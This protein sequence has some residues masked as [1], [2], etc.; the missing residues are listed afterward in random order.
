MMR[1]D[2]VLCQSGAGTRSQVKKALKAGQVMVNGKVE[3][4]PD[5]KV[6]P[7]KDQICLF[8]KKVQ[9]SRYEYYMLYKPAGYVSACRDEKEKTVLELLGEQRR[10]DLFPAGRLDKDTEGLLLITNDGKL[11]HNLLSPKKH[12]DKT[13]YAELLRSLLPDDKKRLE[14]GVDIGDEKPALPAKITFPGRD[15]SKVEITIKEGRFHQIK[16]MFAVCGNEVLYLKRL[17]M[18]SLRLDPLLKKGEYRPLKRE[19]IE[20]LKGFH[21]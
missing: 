20:A 18:G 5:Q 4:N 2:K 17:S 9:F 13:Y 19:E 7:E 11:A 15:L 14:E 12:V 3:K 16:R 1:L 21:T 6:D 8:G 10:K